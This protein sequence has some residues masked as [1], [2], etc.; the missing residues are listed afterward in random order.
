MAQPRDFDDQ[1]GGALAR[2]AVAMVAVALLVGAA[3][4]VALLAAA[5][6]GGLDGSTASGS[7]GPRDSEASLYMPPYEPTEDAESGW[8]L[9]EPSQTPSAL[10]GGGGGTPQAKRSEIT[11]FIAPQQVSPGE[12]INFNGVYEGEE[13]AT[14]QIQRRE[15]GSWTDFPVTATVR[16]GSF[17]TWIVTSQTGRAPFRVYDEAADKASNVVTIQIG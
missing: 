7:T 5:R 8:E 9:P 2:A 15:G 14:L 4:G 13:G 12:R 3:V 16:G 10:P 17:E 1:P 6:I 11:L